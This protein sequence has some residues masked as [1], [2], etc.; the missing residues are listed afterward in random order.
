MQESKSICSRVEDEL[1]SI[2]WSAILAKFTDSCYYILMTDFLKVWYRFSDK[3]AIKEEKQTF[4]PQFGAPIDRILDILKD[5]L[6]DH[7]QN[8]EYTCN[9]ST[10]SDTLS[11]KL[12]TKID[13]YIF[14]WTFEC[15]LMDGGAIK[16]AIFLR[17]HIIMPVLYINKLLAKRASNAVTEVKSIRSVSDASGLRGSKTTVGKT[18]KNDKE[19]EELQSPQEFTEGS[20]FDAFAK[21]SYQHYI[22]CASPSVV[23]SPSSSTRSKLQRN[24]GSSQNILQSVPSTFQLVYPSS[25]QEEQYAVHGEHLPLQQQL[26]DKEECAQSQHGLEYSEYLPHKH[27][28]PQIV[29]T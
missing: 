6:L 27:T 14:Q 22:A 24:S 20:W 10:E 25:V 17:D 11:L 29:T 15:T 12:N 2:A 18:E 21:R 19:E 13:F 3:K 26:Q 9:F 23:A 7:Q 28:H 1:K 5:H 16:H 4:N 8:A